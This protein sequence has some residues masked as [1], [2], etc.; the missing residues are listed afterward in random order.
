MNI[1]Y[2]K[3]YYDTV[4]NESIKMYVENELNGDD[5]DRG[6][7]ESARATAD[8]AT[9]A[10][11]RLLDVLATKELLTAKDIVDIVTGYS[12]DYE[13]MTLVDS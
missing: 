6:S 2:K 7:L 12:D 5:Y 11:G 4:H 9:E 8:N 13:D 3:Q 1:S 10:L